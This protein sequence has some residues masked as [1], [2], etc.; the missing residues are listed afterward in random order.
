MCVRLNMITT[1]VLA[2]A[3]I[4]TPTAAGAMPNMCSVVNTPAFRSCMDLQVR[5][6]VCGP[7]PHPCAAISYYVPETY[8]EVVTNPTETSFH[9]LPGVRQQLAGVKDVAPFAVEDDRGAYGFHAHALPIPY[10]SAGLN[11]LPCA[12]LPPERTCFTAMSEHLGQ[13]WRTGQPDLQQPQFLAWSAVPKA[14]L[15]AGAVQSLGAGAPPSGYPSTPA[16]STDRGSTS[17]Y[18]PSN[19]PVCTG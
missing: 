15:M 7:I 1:V 9:G 14:C 8:I 4:V 17:R 3:A 5:Q 13:G 16:C 2:A 19:H 6:M 11:L 18:P 12:N 10:S